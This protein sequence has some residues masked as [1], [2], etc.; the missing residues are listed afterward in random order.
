MTAGNSPTISVVTPNYNHG[1]YIAQTIR[2]VAAQTRCP[3]EHVIVDDGSTDDSREIIADL[4]KEFPFV[5]LI[6]SEC[7][8]G[9]AAAIYRGLLEAKGRYLMFLGADDALPPWSLERFAQIIEQ[10][11]DTALICGDVELTYKGHPAQRETALFEGRCAGLSVPQRGG[12]AA[13]AGRL[14]HQRWR[15][16]RSPGRGAQRGQ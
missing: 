15:G 12:G 9:A 8:K 6:T 13:A 4:A 5:R 14:C 16:G 7:N 11:P 10:H 2:S 1:H 3:L